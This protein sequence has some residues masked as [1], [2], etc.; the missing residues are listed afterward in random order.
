M[1]KTICLI[2]QKEL[3]QQDYTRKPLKHKSHMGEHKEK[4]EYITAGGLAKDQGVM[5]LPGT[6]TSSS[7]GTP[8]CSQGSQEIKAISQFV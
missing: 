1:H 3:P 4:Q 7:R 8:R 2:E 6:S 5:G